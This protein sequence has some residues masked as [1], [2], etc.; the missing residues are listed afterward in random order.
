MIRE[1]LEMK[2]TDS[3]PEMCNKF[4]AFLGLN[5]PVPMN[6]LLRAID[7]PTF[8]SNLITCRNAPAF[9]DSL[10]ADPRNKTYGPPEIRE[11]K[12]PTSAELITKAAPRL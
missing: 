12:T 6:V 9:L 7:D 2:E 5:K 8:A 10:F 3:L 1:L 4:G 11:A